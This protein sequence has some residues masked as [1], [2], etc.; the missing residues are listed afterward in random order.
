MKSNTLTDNFSAAPSQRSKPLFVP[1]VKPHTVVSEII[2]FVTSFDHA[3][4]PG[5]N[6]RQQMQ[7]IFS[8]AK[9]Q[10]LLVALAEAP[11]FSLNFGKQFAA[12]QAVE[13]ISI[14]RILR[15]ALN[16][17]VQHFFAL[18]GQLFSPFTPYA[19]GVAQI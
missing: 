19:S 9:F 5:S 16:L 14:C 1:L 2:S 3:A 8:S 6:P 18:L 12:V 17:P 11:A 4:L 7:D 10:D 13:S 15:G